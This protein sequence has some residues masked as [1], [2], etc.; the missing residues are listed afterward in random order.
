M[1]NCLKREQKRSVVKALVEGNSIRSTERMLEIHRDTIMRLLLVVGEACQDLLDQLIQ[2]LNVDAIQCDEIWTFVQKKQRRLTDEEKKRRDDIGDEYVFVAMDADS[3]LVINHLI[4]KRDG[5]TT[6]E[7]ICDLSNRLNDET[8][9]QISSDGF[10][11]YVSAI[12]AEFGNTVDYGQIIKDY[13]SEHPGRGRYSPPRV[14][15][16]HK[17]TILGAPAEGDIS[18]SYVERQ[19]LTMRMSMRRFT[20]LTNGFSK[21]LRNLK[22]AVA[23]HF[24]YYN[25]CRVHQSLKVTPAMAAKL[26]DHVWSVDDL[27]DWQPAQVLSTA[28]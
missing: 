3:K 11:S 27:L 12:E 15:T 23:L 19:N 4:G 13:A 9:P 5:Y 1:A 2:N 16:V 21:K 6:R 20:R 18:T 26:T 22:A 24:A 7:F 28:A 10:E 25:F 17:E 8:R 14:S